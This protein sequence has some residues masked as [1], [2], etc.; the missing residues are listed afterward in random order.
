MERT[1]DPIRVAAQAM[2][3]AYTPFLNSH[4]AAC[5]QAYANLRDA[6]DPL[7]AAEVEDVKIEKEFRSSMGEHRD[8]E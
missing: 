6:L 3:D 2:L 7:S 5:T 4:D 8:V 1:D